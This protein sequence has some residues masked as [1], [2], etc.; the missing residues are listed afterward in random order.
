MLMDKHHR[1]SMLYQYKV[2][3]RSQPVLA[4]VSRILKNLDGILNA[5]YAA[6]H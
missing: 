3:S 5:Q 2:T 6:H 4:F 1:C